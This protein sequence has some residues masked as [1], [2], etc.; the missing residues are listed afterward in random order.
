MS[1][2]FVRWVL[3]A[4][5]LAGCYRPS[6]EDCALTC[7]P[8][9]LC[10]DDLS[11]QDGFCRAETRASACPGP[12][13]AILPPIDAEEPVIDADETLPDAS[14]VPDAPPGQ[15]DASCTCN[16]LSQSCCPSDDACDVQAAG[17]PF[18]RAVSTGGQQSD[19]CTDGTRCARGRT[20]VSPEGGFVAGRSSCHEFCS[21][22]ADCQGGGGLCDEAVTGTTFKV[23]TSA[24]SPLGQTGCATGYACTVKLSSFTDRWHTDCRDEGT[25]SSGQSCTSDDQCRAGLVCGPTTLKCARL[26]RVGG[27]GNNCTG[28]Q[29]CKPFGTGALIAGVEYGFCQ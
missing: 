6:F 13:A 20:C 7:G 2:R 12:D 14:P 17:A 23:C 1:V 26:C 3:A 9:G 15:P 10:P 8:G 27:G 28:N 21:S 22:D 16:P 25:L 29:T 11:C 18:C 19:A 24:C 5:L 4:L